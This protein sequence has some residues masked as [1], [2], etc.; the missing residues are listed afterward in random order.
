L[1]IRVLKYVKSYEGCYNTCLDFVLLYR[2]GTTG[3]NHVVD[4]NHFVNRSFGI[5][6]NKNITP[7]LNN[8]CHV[9]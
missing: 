2:N 3:I 7:T 5:F 8:N 4:P 9:V 6:L 1:R